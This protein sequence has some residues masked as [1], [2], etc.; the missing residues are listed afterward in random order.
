MHDSIPDRYP[1]DAEEASKEEG[2]VPLFNP[3]DF[4]A[5]RGFVLKS[6][7]RMKYLV[8]RTLIVITTTGAT[9]RY[10]A[11]STGG[12]NTVF[13]E[14]ELEPWEEESNDPEQ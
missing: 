10:Q 4:A 13:D 8:K 14:T 11:R 2:I 5:R 12:M 7:A 9:I 1:P 6:G 3:G